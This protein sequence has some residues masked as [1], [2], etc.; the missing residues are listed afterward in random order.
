M[1]SILPEA[2]TRSR[3]SVDAGPGA[4]PQSSSTR[5]RQQR[6]VNPPAIVLGGEAIGL[7]VQR[8][9]ARAEVSVWA[10]GGPNGL[11]RYSRHT[12]GYASLGS[13]SREDIYDRWLEWLEDEAPRGAVLLPCADEGL[14]LVVRHRTTL[15]DLGYVLIE[16][17]DDVLAAM[18]DKERT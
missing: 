9:L 7:Q 1:A 17:N 10:V 6:Q 4:R 5:T 15:E 8:H 16:A 13:K 18:L 3:R 14:E 2:G 11:L 12:R